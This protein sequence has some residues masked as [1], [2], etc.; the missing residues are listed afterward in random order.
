MI[1]EQNNYFL[2]YLGKMKKII[3]IVKSG[4]ARYEEAESKVN[5]LPAEERYEKYEEIYKIEEEKYKKNKEMYE[6][7]KVDEETIERTRRVS[8]EWVDDMKT[9]EKIENEADTEQGY[10]QE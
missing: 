1:L 3:L 9:G 8:E 5:D 10:E 2:I 7:Y 4:K 6:K